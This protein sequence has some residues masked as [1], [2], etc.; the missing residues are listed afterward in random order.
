[1]LGFAG[2][3][4]VRGPLESPLSSGYSRRRHAIPQSCLP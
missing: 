2:G 4:I 1:M 3:E